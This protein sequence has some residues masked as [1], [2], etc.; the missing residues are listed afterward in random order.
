MTENGPPRQQRLRF[1]IG[2][3]M[4]FII[5]AAVLTCA[6]L[7]CHFLGL[8]T[9]ISMLMQTSFSQGAGDTAVFIGGIVYF[10]LHICYVVLVPILLGASAIMFIL[11]RLVS[12]KRRRHVPRTA[13]PTCP[14]ERPAEQSS[15]AGNTT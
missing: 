1:P 15:S 7:A 2:W 8:R 11:M 13:V 5:L 14:I 9:N 3:P 10:V 12:P 4:R 6:Y